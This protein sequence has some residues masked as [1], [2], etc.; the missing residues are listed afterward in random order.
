MLRAM[1][2]AALS[3]LH[4]ALRAAAPV[5]AYGLEDAPTL[6]AFLHYFGARRADPDF[7][8]ARASLALWG[9]QTRPM[10]PE[11]GPPFA[12]AVRESAGKDAPASRLAA[13]CAALPAAPVPGGLGPALLAGDAALL[14]RSLLPLMREPGTGAAAL[15]LAWDTL[16]RLGSPDLARACAAGCVLPPEAEPLRGRLLAEVAFHYEAPATALAA[17]DALDPAWGLWAAQRRAECLAASGETEEAARLY[18]D[19][20]GAMPWHVN[21]ALRLHGLRSPEP[22]DAGLTERVEAAVCVYSWN[23]RELLAATLD[24]L[25]ASRLGRAAVAV[26]D[27]GSDDGTWEMLAARAGRFARFLPVRLPVNVGAPA[28]RNWL[29]TLPEVRAAS[30]AVFLD[31]DVELPPDW[32]DR[33]LAA[34]EAAKARGERPGAVGCRITEARRPFGLQSADY[35]LFPPQPS[36]EPEAL[37]IG[38]FDNCGG[39]LDAGLFTYARSC[40]SVSGCC[41]AV[42]REA[43][44]AA[45]AFDVRFTPTQFDDLDRDMRSCLAGFPSLY[46]GRLTVRHVQHSSLAKAQTP[47]QVGH[48]QGNRVKLEGKYLD[49]DL[50][51]LARADAERCWAHLERVLPELADGA[52]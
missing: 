36:D 30:W 2:P 11:Y 27:N 15:A 4:A 9:W 7:A 48:I 40:L 34:G 46:E 31:D 35:H 37:R 10:H 23:K 19:L 33:L 24:S 18:A 26:L 47:A 50:T 32:L 51:R 5:W 8:A 22:P 12:S 45:G 52:A 29:L 20:W 6:A 41:H 25:A 28:A 1:P 39:Q 3:P 17:L 21:L 49:E 44:D 16:L 43:L 14:V 13:A 42:S 38:V